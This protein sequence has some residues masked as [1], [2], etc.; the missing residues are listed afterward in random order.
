M[1][2]DI[3]KE[4]RLISLRTHSSEE[5]VDSMFDEAVKLLAQHDVA[6]ASLLQRRLSLGYA[7]AARLLDQLEEAGVIG[8]AEGAKPREVLISSYEDYTNKSFKKPNVTPEET[9]PDWNSY[10]SPDWKALVAQ[11]SS[12]KLFEEISKNSHTSPLSFALG[13]EKESLKITSLTDTPHCIITGSPQSKKLEYIDS[14]LVSLLTFSSPKHLRIVLLDGAHYLSPYT[15]IPH[16]LTPVTAEPDKALSALRWGEMELDVRWNI[17]SKANCRDI[18]SFNKSSSNPMSHIVY[19]I[20][21]IDEH[22]SYAKNEFTEVLKKLTSQGSRAGI[23][24][25]LVSDSLASRS[26]PKEIQEN[27]P[28]I[29]SFKST[30][31]GISKP[32][33]SEDLKPNELLFKNDSDNTVIKLDAPFF[34][35]STVLNILKELKLG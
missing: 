4:A 13:W 33:D 14:I 6:S 7:R 11:S 18:A 8:P 24:I 22:M 19:V 32:K 34:D 21:Q 35:E 15:G 26:I 16:L 5:P 25:V 9:D 30:W 23:H 29:I 10:K 27:I 1:P 12:K 2:R 3:I 20:T 28:A 17:F 31:E